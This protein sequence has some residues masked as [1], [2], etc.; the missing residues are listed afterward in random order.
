[1]AQLTAPDP[2]QAKTQIVNAVEAALQELTNV[3]HSLQSHTRALSAAKQDLKRSRDREEVLE[4]ELA[5]HRVAARALRVWLHFHTGK[6]LIEA[7][8]QELVDLAIES[9]EQMKDAGAQVVKTVVPLL[10]QK[11]GPVILEIAAEAGPRPVEDVP[12]QPDRA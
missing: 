1:M 8:P 4:A 2:D 10:M 6:S 11:L 7:T 5:D 3:R 9:L 12:V